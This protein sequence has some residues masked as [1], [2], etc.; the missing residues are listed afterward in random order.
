MSVHVR[1]TGAVFTRSRILIL[2]G[3]AVVLIGGVTVFLVTRTTAKQPV[4]S[5]VLGVSTSQGATASPSPG[6]SST[7]TPSPAPT[8]SPTVATNATSAAARS[9]TSGGTGS[10][11]PDCTTVARFATL[12]VGLT[13]YRQNQTVQTT[14]GITNNGPTCVHTN[15][16]VTANYLASNGAT[17]N[18]QTFAVTSS[19]TW[20]SHQTLS[21]TLNWTLENCATSPCT[22]VPPGT[23]TVS[24]TWPGVKA[25]TESFNVISSTECLASEV[26]VGM[27]TRTSFTAG[28]TVVVNGT[29]TNLSN[30]TCAVGQ[31]TELIIKNQNGNVV[32]AEG[33]GSSSNSQTWNPGQVLTIPYSWNQAICNGTCVP[34]PRGKYNVTF[35]DTDTGVSTGP[36]TIQLT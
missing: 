33:L 26:G 30:H 32:F 17:V 5:G 2:A 20:A 14:T 12:Q 3:A 11:T 21:A 31:A 29:L 25:L 27:T 19:S 28:Q 1:E 10:G 15:K 36:L 6:S 35:T 4:R 7:P 23:Y 8:P 34:A 22:A 18:G 24:V 16:T 9:S 13:T